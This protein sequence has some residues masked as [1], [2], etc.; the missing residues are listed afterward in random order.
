RFTDL[1][2]VTSHAI[3][4]AYATADGTFVER[5]RFATEGRTHLSAIGEPLADG[6][7]LLA[8]GS[9]NEGFLTIVTIS[10]GG[11]GAPEPAGI[12]TFR[13]DAH[14]LTVA[15]ANGDQFPDVAGTGANG[16]FLSVTSDGR[17]PQQP[18]WYDES[19]RYEFLRDL[20]GDGWAEL[21]STDLGSTLVYTLRGGRQYRALIPAGGRRV[22]VADMNGDTKPDVVFDSEYSFKVVPGSGVFA[23]EAPQSIWTYSVNGTLVLH[24]VDRDGTSDAVINEGPQIAVHR[25]QRDA[26]LRE[27]VWSLSGTAITPVA[28]ADFDGDG[29][30]DA[31]WGGEQPGRFFVASG[32]GDGT[33]ATHPFY[34]FEVGIGGFAHVQRMRLFATDLTSDSR[35]DVIAFGGQ[36]PHI[37]GLR[38]DGQGGFAERVGIPLEEGSQLF[39]V[40]DVDRD[41]KQD[42]VTA[43]GGS[44]AIHAGRGDM[45]F[46][47]PLRLSM[48]GALIGVADFN[49]DG[50][51][52]LVDAAGN[53][54]LNQGDGTFGATVANPVSLSGCRELLFG[55]VS[56]DGGADVVCGGNFGWTIVIHERDGKFRAPVVFDQAFLTRPALGD[57]NRDNRADLVE[58]AFGWATVLL[59]RGDGTFEMRRQW[60][61]G[62]DLRGDDDTEMTIADFNGDGLAD[63]A[64]GT[65]FLFGDG[66]GGLGGGV[67]FPFLPQ[68]LL[69]AADVDGNGSL[70]L[71][72]ID[73][74][75]GVNVLRTRISPAGT[76]AMPLQ[77]ATAPNPSRYGEEVAVTAST[78]PA[79]LQVHTARVGLVIDGQTYGSA[80]IAG[81]K[82]VFPIAF[83]V[84]SHTL[85][86]EFRGDP[87]FADA[88]ADAAQSVTKGESRIMR[89]NFV[90]PVLRP[91]EV[92][93]FIVSVVPDYPARLDAPTGTLRVMDNGA[94]AAESF[95]VPHGLARLRYSSLVEGRHELR[96]DYGGNENYLPSST[97]TFVV[98]VSS[99]KAP[100]IS[101]RANV[102][103]TDAE[104][105]VT[106]VGDLTLRPVT[107][108][109][110]F[111][112][113]QTVVGTAT[114]SADQR[115]TLRLSGL[116]AGAHTIEVEY[117]GN[118][119]YAPVT[120]TV[121]FAIQ[122][123]GPRRRA[124]RS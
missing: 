3:V 66:T 58:V 73:G 75:S 91:G 93:T 117:G 50:A 19:H 83:T 106:L 9:Y 70:D 1:I 12:V 105:V 101:T 79:S 56:G 22:S 80:P 72:G 13:G 34:R 4:F 59:S 23:W 82:A 35:P 32:N 86:V 124:S 113:G 38:N 41:G 123:S 65:H 2:A 102:T 69:A 27:P 118:D 42:L 37:E 115:A 51:P 47:A 45:T 97:E 18:Q 85:R 49:G 89:E 5:Q 100:R 36:F 57:L 6:R 78:T 46:A 120:S 48:P 71:L 24:D 103:G 84:G 63:L 88:A 99:R 33:F 104:L 8:V 98:E 54:R 92:F 53:V 11:G 116:A 122:G 60:A 119:V 110:T 52:D 111:R 68:E 64:A 76:H 62:L 21:L 20:D 29:R 107:G 95:V 43:D 28:L 90:P 55:D 40:A 112:S 61:A 44:V 10:V 15:D 74:G 25:G 67:T 77:L 121:T 16:A 39:G 26:A 109:V 114:V 87:H 30:V 17:R 7:R 14:E 81:A 31:A 94:I 108:T 96:V